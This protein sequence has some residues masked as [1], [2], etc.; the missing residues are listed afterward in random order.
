[1]HAAAVMTHRVQ[2]NRRKM[3]LVS[4]FLE[5]GAPFIAAGKRSSVDCTHQHI[6]CV[7][8]THYCVTQ[9]LW[10]WFCAF[11]DEEPTVSDR[12][13]LANTMAHLD[14]QHLLKDAKTALMPM[15]RTID[16]WE[17]VCGFRASLCLVVFVHMLKSVAW[18]RPHRTES[19]CIKSPE[20]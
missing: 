2:P 11:P 8:N 1:M 16:G 19:T 17:Q 15:L 10:K 12:C 7:T 3:L 18:C 20:P 13:G 9:L 4:E 14:I 5:F 6:E